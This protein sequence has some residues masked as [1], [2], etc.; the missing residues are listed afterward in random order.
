[1]ITTTLTV[2]G[3]H[4]ASCVS[5]IEKALRKQGGVDDAN[6]NL[7]TQQATVS[8]DPQVAGVQDLIRTIQVAG[9]EAQPGDSPPGIHHHGQRQ[10]GSHAAQTHDHGSSKA[11]VGWWLIASIV[12]AAVTVALAMTWK[13][14]VSAWAQLLLATPVQFVLGWSFYRGA[15]KSLRHARA[16]MDTLVALGTSVA[17]GYSVVQVL[18]GQ[19]VVYFDS[20]AVI[21]VLVAVG[22]MLESRAKA[23]AAQAI[24]SLMNLQPPKATVL[25]DEQELTI[26]VDQIRPG[27]IVI[28]RP[29]QR[30]PVDGQ[31]TQG[32]S[33]VDQ[34]LVTGESL[35]IEV[36]PGDTV[37]GGTVN[38]TGAF[39]FQA[40]KT[41]QDMLLS[42]IVELVR[43]AQGTKAQIQRVVDKVA[44]YFVP[45]V[46]M[47]AIGA[48]LGWAVIGGSWPTGLLAMIAV[49]IVACPCA[50]G[51]ATP[52]AIMVGTGL[53]ARHG[54]LI[55]DAGAFE[56][57]GKL[58]DVIL[59]KTGTL[60][61]N[62]AQVTQ[63]LAV[64][65]AMETDTLLR[66]AASVEQYSEHPLGKAIL[67][68]AKR[69]GIAISPVQDFRS[70]TAAG[71]VGRVEAHNV[72]VGR[73]TSLT[74][75]GISGIDGLL[76]SQD[77]LAMEEKCKT[78]VA[79]AI[80]KQ[81]VGLIG[82]DEKIK[83]GA[84]RVIQEL[85]R[86]GLSVTMMTGD[87]QGAAQSVATR[88]GIDR[89]L[90]QVQ[91]ADKQN[92][93]RQL[94]ADGRVVAMVGDGINDAPA[95]AAA[96]IGIAMGTGGSDIAKEA[97]HVVLVGQDLDGLVKAIT[98]SR[99]TLRRIYTGLFWAF[100]YN[101]ALI[102]LAV[103]GWL[104]PMFAAAAMS[105]SSVSVVLN[106]LWLRHCWPAKGHD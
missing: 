59:D 93:V 70:I 74:G 49:L 92:K 5:R 41:G 101:S 90:A 40:T 21:L 4:C 102:P 7:V 39:Q 3:M 25:R 26:D 29:G 6:V 55:K 54:I 82:F 100:A 24:H 27:D 52:T 38:Q 53:G 103:L 80:D 2:R 73:L 78:Q 91:P 45:S 22:R 97:G 95:L 48:L 75:L 77:L 96:D 23:T 14:P 19:P 68:H 43:Q 34:S 69:E 58:T 33:E 76:T 99:A 56:R 8:H 83:P 64:D 46:I 87:Q 98:L 61:D 62:Q 1:M 15:L 104:H 57:A 10:S 36:G 31:V 42:Q 11:G 47:I 79:V 106:A 32:Q 51:L 86:L 88:L 67:E 12:L 85:H 84:Q 17:Y 105:L 35:P 28:V 81:V 66:L 37:I 44:S 18:T 72:A 50:L 94:Q 63:V 71:V 89:V 9:Y 20:A 30:V 65:R 60:T 16:D 13:S